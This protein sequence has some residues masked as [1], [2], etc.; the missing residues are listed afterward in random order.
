MIYRGPGILVV[1][2]F[3]SS[4]LLSRQKALP[5]TNRKTEKERLADGGMGEPNQ[6][7]RERLVLYKSFNI[8]CRE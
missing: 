8:L 1:E 3:V 7:L 2:R 6:Q 5:A 4:P